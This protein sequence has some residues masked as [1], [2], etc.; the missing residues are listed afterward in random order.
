MKDVEHSIIDFAMV[1]K[2]KENLLD[3]TCGFVKYKR[4]TE[5]HID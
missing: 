2:M 3:K 1:K 5:Q 4:D